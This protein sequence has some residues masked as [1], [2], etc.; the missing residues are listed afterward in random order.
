MLGGAG[1]YSQEETFAFNVLVSNNQSY[2]SGSAL[3]ALTRGAMLSTWTMRTPDDLSYA[4][5]RLPAMAEK[6]WQYRGYPVP[7]TGPESFGAWAR[8]WAVVDRA[9]DAIMGPTPLMYEC[10]PD[11][12][13]VPNAFGNGSSY[14]DDCGTCRPSDTPPTPPD[15]Y[16]L[17]GRIFLTDGRFNASF[18]N[19]TGNGQPGGIAGADAVC[20][21]QAASHPAPA[22]AKGGVFK[23][24]LAAESGCGTSGN[25]PCRRATVTPGAGDG[26][27]DWPV[28]ASGAYYGLDGSS[29]R[30][31][32]NSSAMLQTPAA[33]GFGGVNQAAGFS[34]PGWVTSAN[35]T[36]DGWRWAV[37]MP[38]PPEAPYGFTVTLGWSGFPVYWEGGGNFPCGAIEFFC[39]EVLPPAAA[40]AAAAA[41]TGH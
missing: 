30:A 23:A 13:C 15:G 20:A 8:R 9:L 11:L 1:P 21:A 10:S 32:A 36:C 24:L 4:R 34:S 16:V 14:Q 26:S 40:P 5:Q 17:G 6:A 3:D 2:F 27:I 28:R 18:L 38:T 19:A 39:I 25:D 31:L 35:G 37:G 33:S 7:A 22:W 12:Q 29:L 41:A